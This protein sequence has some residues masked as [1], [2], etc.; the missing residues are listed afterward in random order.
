VRKPLAALVGGLLFVVSASNARAEG[1]NLT[2]RPAPEIAATDGLAGWSPSASLASFRGSPVAVKF[3]FAACPACRTSMPEFEALYRAYGPRGVRFVAVA[4]DDRG[5]MESWWRR[6][7]F[8]VPVALDPSGTTS[9][10][11]GVRSYPTTY[12]IGADGT[13]VSYQR[14]SAAVL[15]AALASG[16]AA[17]P[18]AAPAFVAA[19]TPVAAPVAPATNRSRASGSASDPIDARVLR[20]LD[21]LGD[22]PA[23][24]ADAREAARGNDYGEVLRQAEAHLDPS[25]ETPDVL[26]AAGRARRVAL[27]RYDLR[28]AR[29]EHRWAMHDER[30]AY[31]ALLAM[32]QDFH[33]TTVERPLIERAHRVYAVLAGR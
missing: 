29:I 24:L 30:G 18:V 7:G 14:I 8:T 32:A 13:V 21:E 33:D 23:A 15:D 1:T 17:R 5:N 16:G 22:L 27:A 12:V 19:P 2:G 20:N 11:Y 28:L 25:R 9:S 6:A 4:Y 3:L 26:A 10:R 31:L